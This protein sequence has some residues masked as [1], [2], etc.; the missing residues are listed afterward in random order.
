LQRALVLEFLHSLGRQLTNYGDSISS[1][2][3]PVSTCKD[4]DTLTESRKLMKDVIQIDSDL[5]R[6]QI[7]WND[8]VVHPDTLSKCGAINR[9][10]FVF[11]P[12]VNLEAAVNIEP[13]FL[14][15]YIFKHSG[16]S[17]IRIH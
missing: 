6:F 10:A 13:H 15:P 17:G 8:Y 14:A 16:G 12:H 3:L 11:S 7:G 5:V 4:L 9:P 1:G 2:S